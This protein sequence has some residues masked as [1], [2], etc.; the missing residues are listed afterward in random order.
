MGC[1]FS[2]ELTPVLPGET[3]CLIE[4]PC[5]D[6]LTEVTEQVRQHALTLAQHVRLA[7][8]E[9]RATEGTTQTK[10]LEDDGHEK[11]D[12]KVGT[13][14]STPG[15]KNDLRSAHH[16]EENGAILIT[17]STN[18]HTHTNTNAEAGVAHTAGPRCAPASYREVPTLSP[19]TQNA[20]VRAVRCS[21]PPAG[22]RQHKLCSAPVRLPSG[23]GLG[24]VA[25]SEPAVDQPPPLSPCHEEQ[26][27]STES[28]HEEA[29]AVTATSRQDLETRTRRFYTICSIDTDDLEHDL[30]HSRP[31]TAGETP[32]ER[33]AEA[34]TAAPEES[35]VCDWSHDVRSSQSQDKE[36]SPEQSHTAVPSQTLSEEPVSQHAVGLNCDLLP[37]CSGQMGEEEPASTHNTHGSTDDPLVTSHTDTSVC[38]E[39]SKET[40]VTEDGVCSVEGRMNLGGHRT[41]EDAAVELQEDEPEQDAIIGSSQTTA[42]HIP[43]KDASNQRPV[44]L[45][46]DFTPEQ[47]IEEMALPLSEVRDTI[48]ACRN[49]NEEV[50]VCLSDA[51]GTTLTNVS[52]VYTTSPTPSS[53]PAELTALS[54]PSALS[55]LKAA[56]HQHNAIASDTADV[57]SHDQSDLNSRR[58]LHDAGFAEREQ[59]LKSS[60]AASFSSDSGQCFLDVLLREGHTHTAGPA[61]AE[62]AEEVVSTAVP[63]T[64][65]SASQVE[66][67]GSEELSSESSDGFMV[68]NTI[69]GDSG[70]EQPPPAESEFAPSTPP[71]SAASPCTS[72]EEA[73]RSFSSDNE[74]V[75]SACGCTETQQMVNSAERVFLREREEGD[76]T[77][78]ARGGG[79]DLPLTMQDTDEECSRSPQMSPEAPESLTS[80]V[81]SDS[82]VVLL[83]RGE[84]ECLNPLRESVAVAHT[85]HVTPD[86]GTSPTERPSHSPHVHPDTRDSLVLS[87]DEPSLIN[88][89]E[90]P[91]LTVV[92][93]A[94]IDAYAS[95]PSYEIHN[96]CQETPAN[97]EE[98][99][100]REMVSELLGE[101]GGDSVCRLFPEP[102]IRLGLGG[103]STGWAQGVSDAPPR[104]DEGTTGADAEHIPD[105][106]SELQPSMALLGA[107]PYSTVTPLGGCV[108]DW[109][110]EGSQFGPIAA[111]SLNPNA[112]VWPNPNVNLSNGPPSCL[113]PQQ[114]CSQCSMD[115]TNQE[116][117]LSDYM[118]TMDLAQP[119]TAEYQTLTGG[120]PGG[121]VEPPEQPVTD[122][123]KQQLK[124]LLE[125]YLSRERLTT[126][127]YLMSQM[128]C[129]QY[130][131]I[132]TMASL[133]EIRRIS[134][135]LDLITDILKSSPLLQVSPCGQRVRPTQSRCVLILR[136]IPNST[137]KEEVEALLDG[138][139]IPE[140]Q[141]CE[142]V[143]NDNWF[144]TFKSEADA[145]QAY[146]YLREEVRQFK[147]KPIMARIKTRTMAV[148][149]YRPKNGYRLNELDQSSSHYSSYAPP[150]SYQQACMYR[151]PDEWAYGFTNHM[152]TSSV[153]SY[154][155]QHPAMMNGFVE[156]VSEASNLKTHNWNKRNPQWT[157]HRDNGEYFPPSSEQERESP[158]HGSYQAKPRRGRS[159]SHMHNHSGGG[160]RV[161]SKKD[162]SPTPDWTR[163]GNVSQ[164]R[165]GTPRPGYKYARG[166]RNPQSQ[167]PPHQRSPPLELGL[168]SFPPLLP[169]NTTVATKPAAN[170]IVKSPVSIKLCES[171]PVTSQE[172]QPITR[173]D[174]KDHEVTS[175]SPAA[176]FTQEHVTESKRLSY[177]Q[178]CQGA[179]PSK[180]VPSTVHASPEADDAPPYPDQAPNAALMSK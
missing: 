29:H 124:T 141:R 58:P 76:E 6:G 154:L 125:L 44:F 120:D 62:D 109:H 7:E 40:T 123:L 168:I 113:Q 143:N 66:M 127:L 93:P 25:E 20:V 19:V 67:D 150:C 132:K 164:R 80:D 138:D 156:G 5:H 2:K 119:G 166:V 81:P 86:G 160:W 39:G 95:T 104:Q 97:M 108:W 10:P 33:T 88:S 112:E 87:D 70:V 172:P 96:L 18:R 30:F 105:S 3:S 4:P 50:D 59:Q 163:R 9:T 106:V 79:I 152:W 176:E 90:D 15:G 149:S 49:D 65:E 27:D 170:R 146:R 115:L 85:E 82:E 38:D 69:T 165:R 100:M 131:S 24:N 77:S 161:N 107:Y 56:S 52:S 68:K 130:I 129:D 157:N 116:G 63:E 75:T 55:H 177:A 42:A 151:V 74:A 134:T 8:E 136:E 118:S 16:H 46:I 73:E 17:P 78:A 92:D 36:E 173:R 139:N 22:P 43:D 175:D 60:D 35:S 180:P 101:D 145:Q 117:Y 98:G 54:C 57:R 47:L 51:A 174:A 144:V 14:A 12:N 83:Q 137:P 121:D 158:Q 84:P 162:R 102:W 178:V 103:G 48:P 72:P 45:E 153:T 53:P 71:S 31:Q 37:L 140:F 128:D 28:E 41:T 155:E 34:G 114:Q 169:A 32:S 13:E 171:V 148:T 64:V 89:Q 167:S 159:R 122:E 179:S 110:T 147:G 23:D 11:P 135:N 91:A 133:D 21:Q 126:N 142:F 26:Q 111:P 61:E 1:C 99:G 94:Q